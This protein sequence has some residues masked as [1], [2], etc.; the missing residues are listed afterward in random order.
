[1]IISPSMGSRVDEVFIMAPL[2]P[3]QLF[4]SSFILSWQRDDG[5]PCSYCEVGCVGIVGWIHSPLRPLA[6]G[7]RVEPR[8]HS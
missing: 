5:E 1:M 4:Q 3:A 8:V 6:R 7:R 2:P